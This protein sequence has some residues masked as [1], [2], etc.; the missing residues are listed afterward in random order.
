[1]K[2]SLQVG[3]SLQRRFTIDRERTIDFMGDDGRVYATPMLVHDIEHCCRDL[4]LEH[5]DDGEDSVGTAVSVQHTAATLLDMNVTVTVTIAA[6]E[7]RLVRL[8]AKAEDD[9]EPI[10]SGSHTRFVVDRGKTIERLKAKRLKY[11]RQGAKPED[12]AT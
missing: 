12:A 2:S 9:L 10:G 11:T 3:L 8:D 7:G 1:M 6:V 4:I 5:L